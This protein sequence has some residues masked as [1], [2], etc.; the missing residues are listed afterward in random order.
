MISNFLKLEPKKREQ[1]L[2]AAINEFAQKDYKNAST[3]E[4]VKKAGISKGLIFH[5]FKNKK[6]LYIFLYDYLIEIIES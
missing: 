2:N 1:I 4:I 5:Y 6:Q 3:N